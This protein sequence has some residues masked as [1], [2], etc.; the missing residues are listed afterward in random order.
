ME[1]LTD[2]AHIPFTHAG[3]IGRGNRIEPI[4]MKTVF[5]TLGGKAEDI[6]G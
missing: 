5:D 1:N 2:P 6:Q 4:S 3:T